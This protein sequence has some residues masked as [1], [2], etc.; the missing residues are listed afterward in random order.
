M[1]TK[2]SLVREPLADPQER[3]LLYIEQHWHMMRHA[4]MAEVLGKTER[5][6]GSLCCTYGWYP[7][8]RVRLQ[9]GTNGE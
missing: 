6:V 4:E 2:R 5:V 9:W 8:A 3:P 1:S 7:R